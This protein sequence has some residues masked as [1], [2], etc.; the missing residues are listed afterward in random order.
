M[1][2]KIIN[3]I[4]FRIIRNVHNIYLRN[5]LCRILKLFLP[6]IE[7]ISGNN[8]LNLND[9]EESMLIS[10]QKEGLVD[11]GIVLSET[12][13]TSIINELKVLNCYDLDNENLSIVDL[14][15]V[16]KTTQLANYKREDLIAIP[17]IIQIANDSRIINI[18]SK[19]LGVKPTISNIN[20]WWSFGDREVAKEAQYFHRDVDDY[21]FVKMFFYLTDV[22]EE[23]GPHIFVKGSHKINKLL[24]LRRFNDNEVVENF[25]NQIVTLVRPKGSC[26]IEDTYG[27]HKGQLPVNG[28]RLLLQ[29][30]YSYLPLHVENYSPKESTLS[31]ILNLDKYINRLVLK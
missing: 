24:Q 23:N 4:S 30:Q 31:E 11:L 7:T 25:E 2:K 17:E 16:S 21:K 5:L 22:K 6:K 29:I 10:L 13:I 9:S 12:N 3:K 27:I 1:M 19:Y 28:K 15:D 18:V 8:I 26:F 14:N 20:C